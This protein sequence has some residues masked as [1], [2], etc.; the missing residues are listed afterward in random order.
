MKFQSCDHSFDCIPNA[1]E[2]HARVARPFLPRAG[3]AIHPALRERE[4][5]GFETNDHPLSAL[6]T[7]L[8]LQLLYR[9][10]K[11]YLSDEFERATLCIMLHHRYTMLLP[12]IFM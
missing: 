2:N 7:L 9:D 10:H 11:D 6:S 4:G 3:D 12:S 5:S 8:K 1:H